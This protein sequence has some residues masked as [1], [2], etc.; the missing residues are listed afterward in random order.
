LERQRL[1]LFEDYL[2]NTSWGY[3]S[4]NEAYL[5]SKYKINVL[6]LGKLKKLLINEG[7]EV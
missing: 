5:A 1:S 7:G 6:K 2:K 4:K 3:N